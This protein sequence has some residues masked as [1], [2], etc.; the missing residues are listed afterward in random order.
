MILVDMCKSKTKL[1]VLLRFSYLWSVYQCISVYMVPESYTYI[2]SWLADH[3]YEGNLNHRPP[4]S[5]GTHLH[6]LIAF[7]VLFFI[8]AKA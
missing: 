4:T 6:S 1:Q 8:I 2:H 7:Q 5:K 3:Y